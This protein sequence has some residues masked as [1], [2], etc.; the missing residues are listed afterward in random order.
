MYW[1]VC[2]I[3]ILI[4]FCLFTVFCICNILITNVFDESLKEKA[5]AYDKFD[6][7]NERSG[8]SSDSDV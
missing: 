3:F 7:E 8:V 4:N 1:S 6:D 5:E 2:L